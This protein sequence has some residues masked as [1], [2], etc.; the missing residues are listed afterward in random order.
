[1]PSNKYDFQVGDIIIEEDKFWDSP[2]KAYAYHILDVIST[3][4]P[5]P[6]GYIPQDC[7]LSVMFASISGSDMMTDG[8]YSKEAEMVLHTPFFFSEKVWE[9]SSCSTRKIRG[10][11][12]Y[13]LQNVVWKLSSK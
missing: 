5:N 4:S 10:D 12:E 11:K 6:E 3:E 13:T 9:T 1:M 7:I 8:Y 2:S